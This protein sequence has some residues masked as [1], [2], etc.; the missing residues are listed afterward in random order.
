MNVQFDHDMIT[1]EEELT[2]IQEFIASEAFTNSKYSR[3]VYGRF[4][5]KLKRERRTGRQNIWASP[6]GFLLL[7][8]RID[9]PNS[10]F[11][12]FVHVIVHVIVMLCINYSV[13]GGEKI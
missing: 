2:C 12:E 8:K 11:V 5:K 6:W 4:K 7:D 10:W 9:N 1:D 13:Q 3:K